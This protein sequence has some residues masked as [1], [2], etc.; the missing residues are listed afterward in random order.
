MYRAFF[1]HRAKNQQPQPQP[2][3]LLSHPQP[4]LQPQPEKRRMKRRMRRMIHQQLLPSKQELH[5][6]KHSLYEMY[7]KL[8]IVA[9]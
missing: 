9:S 2:L 4:L 3:L 1:M 7:L 6:N 5:I 8:F